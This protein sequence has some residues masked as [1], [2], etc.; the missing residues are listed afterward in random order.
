MKTEVFVTVLPFI[1]F[2]WWLRDRGIVEAVYV[3]FL[4]LCFSCACACVY[5]PVFTVIIINAYRPIIIYLVPI[6][7]IIYYN[8]IMLVTF[9]LFWFS[10]RTSNSYHTIVHILFGRRNIYSNYSLVH[11]D[12]R[13]G[14]VTRLVYTTLAETGLI[15]TCT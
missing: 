2:P 3:I 5:H 7:I 6:T 13:R 4:L 14:R 8:I 1:V 15:R 10:V 11:V 9:Q 12:L